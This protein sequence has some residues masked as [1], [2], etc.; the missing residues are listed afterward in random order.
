MGLL[1]AEVDE[2]DMVEEDA[3]V[4]DVMLEVAF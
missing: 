1:A 2:R 4:R 3:M